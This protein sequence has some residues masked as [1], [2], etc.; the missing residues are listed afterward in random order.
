MFVPHLLDALFDPKAPLKVSISVK[1]VY[2]VLE[3][4]INQ[5]KDE[6]HLGTNFVFSQLDEEFLLEVARPRGSNV[7]LVLR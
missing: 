6:Q 1:L 7:H 2:V 5:T 4:A 3:P